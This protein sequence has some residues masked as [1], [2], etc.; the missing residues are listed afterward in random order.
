MAVVGAFAR[1][2]TERIEQVRGELA[3]LEGVETFDLGDPM[4]VGIL[5]EAGDLDAAHETLTRDVTAV[6]GVLGVWPVS[7]H[8]EATE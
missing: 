1:I 4:K 5:I 2:E 8:L 6:E 3:R 7:V